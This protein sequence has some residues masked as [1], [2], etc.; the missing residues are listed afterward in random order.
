MNTETP[1][2]PPHVA[3]HAGGKHGAITRHKR[4]EPAVAE[5][6]QQ[7]F[8]AGAGKPQFADVMDFRCPGRLQ[9][10]QNCGEP[11]AEGFVQA[12][13]YAAR[14]SHTVSNSTASRT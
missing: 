8:V 2:H 5:L 11:A 1:A 7:H 6:A 3:A 13:S 14:F 4:E 12:N 10:P 9:V